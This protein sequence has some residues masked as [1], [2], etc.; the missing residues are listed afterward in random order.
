MKEIRLFFFLFFQIQ[1][2]IVPY[3]FLTDHHGRVRWTAV[4]EPSARELAVM[5]NIAKSLLKDLVAESR[6]GAKNLDTT[7]GQTVSRQHKHSM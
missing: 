1:N 5:Q 7:L 2:A 3:V 4:S 6:G